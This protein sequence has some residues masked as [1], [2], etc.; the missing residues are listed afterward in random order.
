MFAGEQAVDGVE[1]HAHEEEGGQHEERPVC[2]GEKGD[3]GADGDGEERGGDGDLVGG[4]AGGEE[5][6]GERAQE[7]LE[8]RLEVVDGGHGAQVK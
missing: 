4:D 5:R 3:T 7:V 6:A 1:G 8:P 2:G